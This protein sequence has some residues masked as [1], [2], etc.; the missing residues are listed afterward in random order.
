MAVTTVEIVYD[1]HCGF[2]RRSL[3]IVSALDLFRALRFHDSHD[4]ATYRL[5]PQ[6]LEAKLD[7][8]MYALVD[9]EPAYQGFFAFRRLIWSSPL[10]WLLIPVFYFPGASR[11]GPR[12]YS[13]VARNRF[14][15]GCSTENC[16]LSQ[17]PN[18]ELGG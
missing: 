10:T 8:A 9:G 5:F 18:P 4:P 2:C 1:G 15:F 11:F 16:E 13:W 17:R 6:L 3:K 14:R 7:E 12:I